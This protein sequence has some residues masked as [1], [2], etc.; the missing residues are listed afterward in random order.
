MTYVELYFSFGFVWL[1]QRKKLASKDGYA[2]GSDGVHGT[3]E[4]ER[5][6]SV[7]E[8]IDRGAENYGMNDIH[9]E[10][11][12]VRCQCT[13]VQWRFHPSVC[14]SCRVRIVLCVVSVWRLF[15]CDEEEA[16]RVVLEI[17]YV[18]TCRFCVSCTR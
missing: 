2:Y 14:I 6:L 7:R 4:P 8:T 10:E 9:S 16:S 5:I 12:S 17:L 1:V 11:E 18:R 3:F 13:F 15:V